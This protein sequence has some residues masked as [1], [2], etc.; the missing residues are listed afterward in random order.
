MQSNLTH[1]THELWTAQRPEGNVRDPHCT[2]EL[3]TL[4]HCKYVLKLCQQ[5]R[6]PQTIKYYL[7]TSLATLCKH[8]YLNIISSRSNYIY[9]FNKL[10]INRKPILLGSYWLRAAFVFM[11][12]LAQQF[13]CCCEKWSI[14]KYSWSIILI[15]IDRW[16]QSVGT[17]A[18]RS[19]DSGLGRAVPMLGASRI[20]VTL[21]EVAL[22]VNYT[23]VCS[24]TLP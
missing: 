24:V 19:R 15:I 22:N 14:S 20:P 16:L 17:H 23:E 10:F 9:F 11:N 21:C 7:I 6:P 12:E 2:N 4:R 18:Q 13:F 3:W 8:Y 5:P 1:T